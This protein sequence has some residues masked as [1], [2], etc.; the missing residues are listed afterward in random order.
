MAEIRRGQ[1]PRRVL[2][3]FDLREWSADVTRKRPG[4][5]ERS[6]SRARATL[7]IPVPERQVQRHRRRDAGPSSARRPRRPEVPRAARCRAGGA[8]PQGQGR[9]SADA[10]GDPAQGPH[11]GP[12]E[13]ADARDADGGD[14]GSSDLA[15]LE[16]WADPNVLVRVG[17]R[18]LTALIATA[19]NNHL[20]PDRAERWL[21]SAR[22]AIELYAGHPAV[23]F[24]DLAA[25][26]W[27]PRHACCGRSRRSSPPTPPSGNGC[28]RWVDTGAL[29]WSPPGLAEVGGPAV[30]ACM[31]DP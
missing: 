17:K 16:R 8:R 22:T 31:G 28:Y 24:A 4:S 10:P 14:L 5:S 18:R 3:A 6:S 23:S 1:P 19:S 30:V 7:R 12:R 2:L 20:G 21:A 15:V 27:R 13:P 29:A 11:Q 9:R 25:E 26:V